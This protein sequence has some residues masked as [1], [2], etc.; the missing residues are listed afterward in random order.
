MN[1]LEATF[2]PKPGSLATAIF[3][4]ATLPGYV[5]TG[6]RPALLVAPA[7]VSCRNAI[8]ILPL[9]FTRALDAP[10]LRFGSCKDLEC[11]PRLT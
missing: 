5:L 6:Q 10:F 1:E 7:G 11:D 4:R 8:H 3:Y 2:I 9:A